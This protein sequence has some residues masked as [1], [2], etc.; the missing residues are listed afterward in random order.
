MLAG[1]KFIADGWFNFCTEDTQTCKYK[2]GAS[3]QDARKVRILFY[4]IDPMLSA[5]EKGASVFDF[6]SS[7]VT[8]SANSMR[9]RPLVKSTSN[10]HYALLASIPKR[11]NNKAVKERKKNS[12]NQ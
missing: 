5:T 10:T 9:V 4:S 12:P 11:N 7:T 1:G 6:T 3:K 2:N 8:P